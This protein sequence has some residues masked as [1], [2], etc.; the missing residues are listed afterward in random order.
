VTDPLIADPADSGQMPA[1][2]VPFTAESGG[3]TLVGVLHRP[4]GPGPHPVVLLLHGFP[5][6]E[7][8]FDL[9]HALSR[10]GYATLVFH[11]RG[12]WGVAGR[13]TWQHGVEDA[14]EVV[15]ALRNP[16][17]AAQHRLDPNRLALVGHSFGGFVALTTA[18]AD[19]GIRAVAS[20]AGFDIGS[21]GAGLR[22]DPQLRAG[23]VDDWVLE[24][25]PLAGTSA[26]ALVEEMAGLP[27]AS[28]LPSLAPRLAGRP[29][30]LIAGSADTAAP[31]GGHHQPLVEA[32]ADARLEEHVWPTDHSLADHR[33]A[34]ARTVITYLDRTV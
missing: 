24:L 19:P 29:V 18:A 27:E 6:F 2:T 32:Y 33:V 26:E 13:W 14:A 31:V 9:A 1:A 17:T 3:V 4:A 7:R 15:T 11:Y 21:A 34:L 12:S 16:Q 5:G 28:R 20:I 8:N 23:Y 22:A 30:L 25:L 10:A